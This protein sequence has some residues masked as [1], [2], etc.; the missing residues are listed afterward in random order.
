MS[1]TF[2]QLAAFHTQNENTIATIKQ[3]FWNKWGHA[4]QHQ[5]LTAGTVGL[6]CTE[7]SAGLW[8]ARQYVDVYVGN[9]KTGKGTGMVARVYED[10]DEWHQ[11]IGAP[12]AG[13]IER[14]QKNEV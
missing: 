2:A 9:C 4:L 10:M 8:D 13:C 14:H 1:V 6:D 5:G 11:T 7:V 12:L 3:Y